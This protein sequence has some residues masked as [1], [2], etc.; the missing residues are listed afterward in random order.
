MDINFSAKLLNNQLWNRQSETHSSFI[1]ILWAWDLSEEFEQ[2]DKITLL[3]A[4]SGVYHFNF[5]Q[6]GMILEINC[7]C[8]SPTK[9]EFYSISDQVKENLF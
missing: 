8:N 6:V 2:L 5:E 3:D 1:D 7:H 9:C 4:Y